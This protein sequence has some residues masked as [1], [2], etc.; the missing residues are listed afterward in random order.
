MITN[1][2]PHR[3]KRAYSAAETPR[4]E[5]EVADTGMRNQLIETYLP[6]VEKVVAVVRRRLPEH[7]DHDDLHSA[8]VIGLIGA[9]ERFND[10]QT[11]TFEGYARLRI[12]GAV[13]DEL[14]R[15]DSC[16]RRSRAMAKRIAAATQEIAQET[17]RSAT[18][19]EISARLDL[20]VAKLQR[21]REAGES[22]RVVSLDAHTGA[23]SD[24]RAL[25]ESIAD[26]S[27]ACVVDSIQKQELQQLLM[28]RLATLP[29]IEKK[30]LALYY[31]EGM[32]LAEIAEIF[33]VTE[34]RVSQ[35]HKKSVTA[36][37]IYLRK[38]Q[39]T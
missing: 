34:S 18:D 33:E 24:Q 3:P 32:K 21:F 17:G 9:V 6:L 27:Q 4:A 39:F 20:T 8:G 13:L 10:A 16:T 14:R 15:N 7:I 28:E 38:A 36:L 25:H 31:F 11:H 35:I 5:R 30:V 23:D 2:Y 22:A 19:E 1:L 29:A 37:R 26:S 12:R